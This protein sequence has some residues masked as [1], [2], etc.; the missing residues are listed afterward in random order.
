MLGQLYDCEPTLT[1][2][3]VVDFCRKGML[4]LERVVPDE[5]NRRAMEFLDVHLDNRVDEILFEEWFIAEV[6]KNPQAAGAVRSL[7]GRNFKLPLGMSNH[8][9]KTPEVAQGWHTDGGSIY[10]PRLD[11]L[12]VFYYPQDTPKELGPLEVV[13]AS[14]FVRTKANYMAQY[15]QI[16]PSLVTAL[17]AGSI[18]VTVYSIWHRRSRSTVDGLRNMLKYNFWRTTPPQR[19]WDTDPRFDFS[20]IN[21]ATGTP[22]FEGF[23]DRPYVAEMFCWLCGLGEEFDFIGG[24]G[25]PIVPETHPGVQQEGVPDSLIPGAMQS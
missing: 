9:V 7:L 16:K 22:L 19:D 17:P 5:I 18:L 11:Y 15:N 8:R 10:T 4:I 13:P 21:F 23:R 3:Q 6:I 12:Q 25:W 14:H 2:E 24:Q 1:D 20:R